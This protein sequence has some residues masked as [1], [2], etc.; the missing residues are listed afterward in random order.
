MDADF[1]GLFTEA[2]KNNKLNELSQTLHLKK[3]TLLSEIDSICTENY[4]S[5]IEM[6][7]HVY[8]L[9]PQLQSVLAVNEELT[10]TAESIQ[11]EH[12]K[13]VIPIK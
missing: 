4:A 2:I 10:R 11:V 3:E 6:F 13:L 5:F 9:K 8:Q 1:L 7:D 12:T